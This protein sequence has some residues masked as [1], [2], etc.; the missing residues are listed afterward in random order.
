MSM[1][2]VR[3]LPNPR[4]KVKDWD[5]DGKPASIYVELGDNTTEIYERRIR[6]PAPQVMKTIELIRAMK[7]NTY[8]G[9]K[10]KHMKK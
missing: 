9:Y 7:G 4:V 8:G 6:Q 1:S 10:A 2:E 3:V 5:I